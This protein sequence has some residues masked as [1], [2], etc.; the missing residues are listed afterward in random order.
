MLEKHIQMF[1]ELRTEG[2]GQEHMAPAGASGRFPGEGSMSKEQRK[3]P[4]PRSCFHGG[5][6]WN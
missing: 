6:L 5:S 2:D 3:G 1:G 4:S